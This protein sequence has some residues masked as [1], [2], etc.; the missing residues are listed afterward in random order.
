MFGRQDGLVQSS[1]GSLGDEVVKA[2]PDISVIE[3]FVAQNA[4][5]LSTA[6]NTH[7]PVLHYCILMGKL[8]VVNALLQT[9]RSIDFTVV[10]EG[11]RSPLHCIC[12]YNPP[13]IMCEMT[14]A[15]VSRLESHPDDRVDWG[16][17][18]A[19]GDDFIGYAARAGYLRSLYPLVKDQFYYANQSKPLVLSYMPTNEDWKGMCNYEAH[20]EVSAVGCSR[21]LYE[22]VLRGTPDM[23]TIRRCLSG[24]A[25]ISFKPDDSV[26]TTLH[27]CLWVGHLDV[28]KLL[29]ETPHDVDFTAVCGRNRKACLHLICAQ[30]SYQ[31]THTL[32]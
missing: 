31:C 3:R 32:K 25:D 19:G 13:D 5:T 8:K 12:Y 23:S 16:Q 15:L 30:F 17:V 9:T 26:F 29:L 4:D 22:E 18:D 24:G 7:D 28:L 10:G 6:T 21:G 14:A 20:F 2:S 27:I 11:N 1:D